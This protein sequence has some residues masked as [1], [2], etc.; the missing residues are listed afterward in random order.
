MENSNSPWTIDVL[1]LAREAWARRD[2]LFATIAGVFVLAVILLHFLRPSYTVSLSVAPVSQNT[3]Q[4]GGG[5][6]GL[7]KLAGVDIG[8]TGDTA[9]FQLF[10]TGLTSRDAAD[11]I[12]LDQPLMRQ[13]F[14]EQWSKE[15]QKWVEPH[16]AVHFLATIVKEVIGV[17]LVPWTPPSGADVQTMLADHLEVDYNPKSPAVSVRMQSKH[18]K[19]TLALLRKLTFVVD[20]QIRESALRRANDYVAY[21][22][23]RIDQEKVVEYKA[24]LLDQ[25]ALQEHTRMM[26]SA[27]VPFAMQTFSQPAVSKKPTS[28][29]AVVM[30]ILALFMG[31][32]LGILLAI[33]AFRRNSPRLFRWRGDA[34]GEADTA[35]R[36]RIHS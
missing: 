36:D 7:A 1:Q 4:L 16:G 2:V 24:T 26:A 21:L 33:R 20:T 23:K 34:R 9:Q 6:G 13:L 18:P 31:T 5:L 3:A 27:H 22:K 35:S 8:G 25:L 30:L 29:K 17:P 11:Q 14:P 19:V 32:G 12:A 15:D 10:I 28:P